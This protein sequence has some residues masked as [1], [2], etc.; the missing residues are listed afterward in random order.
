MAGTM[1]APRSSGPASDPAADFSKY[2]TQP[3]LHAL[4][5]S[6]GGTAIDAGGT[7]RPLLPASS[8]GAVAGGGP[9]SINSHLA[10]MFALQSSTAPLG[11][12]GASLRIGGAGGSGPVG[13]PDTGTPVVGGG[14][15]QGT[16]AMASGGAKP[17][18][19]V[20]ASPLRPITSPSAS[21]TGIARRSSFHRR[22]PAAS[23]DHET[24]LSQLLDDSNASIG[25]IAAARATKR[26]RYGHSRA[27]AG[28]GDDDEGSTT[29]GVVRRTSVGA[30][31]SGIR[32]SGATP[33]G[34][35]APPGAAGEGD[36]VGDLS[37][38]F[39]HLSFDGSASLPAGQGGHTSR[40][41]VSSGRSRSPGALHE[42][43][44]MG[45]TGGIVA[46]GSG[47]SAVVYPAG[48]GLEVIGRAIKI[49]RPVTPTS[50]A[51]LVGS[52]GAGGAGAAAPYQPHL[53]PS[54]STASMPGLLGMSSDST[55][56]LGS[57]VSS[58]AGVAP[59]VVIT[60]SVQGTAT[61]TITAASS[62]VP[63]AP[64]TLPVGASTSGGGGRPMH[65]SPLTGASTG[66]GSASA[67]DDFA[68][69]GVLDDLI[70]TGVDD[71]D[72]EL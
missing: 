50:H 27:S 30:P 45:G 21:G 22:S 63:A 25:D 61:V 59:H 47:G 8:T 65:G 19:G 3:P 55:G 10:G 64:R 23:P 18:L 56:M 26:S 57:A 41:G 12:A 1:A 46:P 66:S 33:G 32:R 14:W 60:T 40:G 28:G 9:L 7:Q 51:A 4:P 69:G 42:D 5:T 54:H 70:L 15:P 29:P 43:T 44:R 68:R 62:K 53:M 72:V 39:G 13:G 48:S 36:G 31:A 37:I 34:V 16:G 6:G 20:S 38:S 17:G 11:T 35:A 52:R 24:S 58:P 49:D 71:G 2:F 67:G